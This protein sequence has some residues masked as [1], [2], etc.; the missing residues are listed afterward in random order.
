M[1]NFFEAGQWVFLHDSDPDANE[2]TL[3]ALNRFP[4]AMT[5]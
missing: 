3:A 4:F 5:I 1:I 2:R